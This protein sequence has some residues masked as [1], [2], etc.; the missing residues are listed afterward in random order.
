[1]IDDARAIAEAVPGAPLIVMGRSLGGA[2]AHELFARPIDRMAGVVFESAFFDL[3]NLI[4]RRG[5]TPPPAFTADELAT[6]DPP[7]SWPD[8]RLP[9]LV[10]HGARDTLIDPREAAAAHAAAGAADKQLVLIPGRGHNDVS[11]ADAYW[12][13]LGGFLDRVAR[14]GEAALARARFFHH[15]WP[16]PHLPV[17]QRLQMD[18]RAPATSIGG[19]IGAT[20]GKSTLAGQLSRQVSPATSSASA[21]PAPAGPGVPAAHD[22]TTKG[23][24]ASKIDWSAKAGVFSSRRDRDGEQVALRGVPRQVQRA[25]GEDVIQAP[26]LRADPRAPRRAPR[27]GDEDSLALAAHIDED[28]WRART[29]AIIETLK[30]TSSKRYEPIRERRIAMSMHMTW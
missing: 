18:S 25:A 13:A 30:V 8:G 10:L 20:I 2:A 28:L 6:F 9:L 27:E 7:A 24:Q 23:S 15:N 5:L 4:R 17:V 21:P 1:V 3:G 14:R 26:D 11:A 22:E 29:Y 16:R 12:A 19:P